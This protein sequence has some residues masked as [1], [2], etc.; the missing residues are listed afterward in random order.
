MK[1]PFDTDSL[2]SGSDDDQPTRDDL[3]YIATNATNYPETQQEFTQERIG[4]YHYTITDDNEVY[5]QD[6][7]KPPGV[8][9]NQWEGRLIWEGAF[10]TYQDAVFFL[11]GR[12]AQDLIKQAADGLKLLE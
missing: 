2:E 12:I 7:M 1:D 10:E 11:R 3:D 4:A 9:E 5:V 6:L 8:P